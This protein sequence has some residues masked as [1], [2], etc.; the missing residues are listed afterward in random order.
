METKMPRIWAVVLILL[1]MI[2]GSFLV[3]IPLI[4]I[5]VKEALNFVVENTNGARIMYSYA[6][7][8]GE[9]D[10]YSLNGDAL[11]S[12]GTGAGFVYNNYGNVK[13]SYANISVIS[14]KSQSGGFVYSNKSNG[15]IENCVS[16]KHTQLHIVRKKLITKNNENFR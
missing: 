14:I 11:V 4:S 2:L 9:I 6:L 16:L 5:C 8:F 1:A 13:E 3:L 12:N 10:N 15:T 7:G